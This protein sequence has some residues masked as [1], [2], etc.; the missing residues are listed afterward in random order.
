[1]RRL[2]RE[3]ALPELFGAVQGAQQELLAI[4]GSSK[5]R[6]RSG[7]AEAAARARLRVTGRALQV[8]A[9]Q[10]ARVL[11]ACLDC[12]DALAVEVAQGFFLNLALLLLALLG[13]IHALVRH[14]GVTAMYVGQALLAQQQHAQ[15]P[16]E[17][18]VE[19]ARVSAALPSG[20]LARALGV[21]AEAM[22]GNGTRASGAQVATTTKD[23]GGAGAA[24]AEGAGDDED[25]L[26]VALGPALARVALPDAPAPWRGLTTRV[27]PTAKGKVGAQGQGRALLATDWSSS[28]EEEEAP[29][30]VAPALVTSQ[31]AEHNVD[32][33][34][35]EDGEPLFVL[36]REPEP[37]ASVAAKPGKEKKEKER[38]P[39]PPAKAAAMPAPSF[40]S[41]LQPPPRAPAPALSLPSIGR[42][43]K[44]KPKKQSAGEEA[45]KNNK[46][47][48]GSPL[49]VIDMIFGAA[50]PQGKKRRK[51]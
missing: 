3:L 31:A 32:D 33:E 19:P 46:A 20:R 37:P 8:A 16:E 47:G 4:R 10:C 1:M 41:Q 38:G 39:K 30:A 36:D 22:G 9:G 48:S 6:S 7:K 11:R 35:E 18:G 49:D 28:E 23:Q 25:D 50:A 43:R 40:L 44:P 34:E 5:P 12:A 26:G 14:A 15:P 42:K 13:R 29:V 21:Q 27:I 51:G 24:A 45:S 2:L 17:A